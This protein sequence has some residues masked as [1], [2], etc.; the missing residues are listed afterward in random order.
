MLLSSRTSPFLRAMDRIILTKL[1][2][3]IG[4]DIN[5]GLQSRL[6]HGERFS[7]VPVRVQSMAA[8]L[9]FVMNVIAAGAIVGA[10]SSSS[11]VSDDFAGGALDGSVWAV[12]DPVGDGTV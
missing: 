7:H 8:Y 11:L 4:R 5:A 1:L 3:W 2:W 10:Q 12:V 6:S 9:A